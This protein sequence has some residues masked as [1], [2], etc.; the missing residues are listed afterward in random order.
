MGVDAAGKDD[1]EV[2]LEGIATMENFF[3]SIG[4]PVTMKELGLNPTDEQIVQ[5]ADG[6]VKASGPVI[7]KAMK[8]GR[9]DIINIYQMANVQ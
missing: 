2:A 1:E 9:D 3:R 8:L 5:M 6:C 7:G 4:M